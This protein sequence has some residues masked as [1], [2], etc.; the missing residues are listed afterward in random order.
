MSYQILNPVYK[1]QPG[2]SLYRSYD[3]FFEAPLHFGGISGFRLDWHFQISNFDEHPT[4]RTLTWQEILS[5]SFARWSLEA[6]VALLSVPRILIVTRDL[7]DNT[8]RGFYRGYHSYRGKN[9]GNEERVLT[10]TA[11][12][13]VMGTASI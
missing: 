6:P 13:A 11:V 5:R 3:D 8:D 4:F 1:C 9:R 10:F 7:H 2:C 12:A